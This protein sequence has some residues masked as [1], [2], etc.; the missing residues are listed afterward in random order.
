[1]QDHLTRR[2]AL[3]LGAATAGLAATGGLSG[4]SAIPFIGGA[5]YT[6][7]LF[8]PGTVTDSDH[9]SFDYEDT[10]QVR[11][12]EDEF[13]SAY[14]DR[15]ESREDSWPLSQTGVAV[16]EVTESLSIDGDTG[17]RVV[18]SFAKDDVTAELEDSD[19]SEETDHGGYTIYQRDER[20]AAGVRKGEFVHARYVAQNTTARD[21]VEALIDAN[22]GDE[23]RYV[24]DSDDFRRLTDELGSGTFVSG[25]T[26]EETEETNSDYGR[27]EGVVASGTTVTVDG[28][29]TDIEVVWVYD[30][31]SDVDM[32]AVENWTDS[33]TFDDVDDVSAGNNG[34]TVTVTGTVDTDDYGV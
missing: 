10:E 26:Q 9:L 34:R 28:A 7:W 33:D 25:G 5:G 23:D 30:A 3:R 8:E 22:A 1:M 13:D 27:F 16:D 15:F 19:F 2:R 4:C 24:D 12:N 18:G 21:V 6:N 17:G 14:Y 31:E 11:N 32:D 20:Y 29:T